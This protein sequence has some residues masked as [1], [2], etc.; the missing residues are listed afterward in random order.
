MLKQPS[1]PV[2]FF[3]ARCLP[4]QPVFPCAVNNTHGVRKGHLVILPFVRHP[5][6]DFFN[7]FREYVKIRK[8]KQA[9]C[10]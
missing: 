1:A 6:I 8:F 10:H 7:I 3:P 2:G 4:W 9:L 5:Y